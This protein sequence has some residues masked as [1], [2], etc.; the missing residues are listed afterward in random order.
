MDNIKSLSWLILQQIPQLTPKLTQALLQCFSHP[1]ELIYSADLAS[2]PEPIRDTIRALQQQGEA[3]AFY[4][5]AFKTLEIADQQNVQVI[6][7]DSEQYPKL[8]KEISC[9]PPVLYCKGNLDLLDSLQLAV[10]GSRKATPLAKQ[11]CFQWSKSLAE[12]GIT[13]TS[14][15]ALGI[16][17]CAHQG[18]LTGNGKTIAV[19]AHGLDCLYPPQ[20]KKLADDITE[21]GLLISE[22]T[23]GKKPIREFFPQRNRLISG[24]S[25]GVL[26]VE[27][28]L[29]SGSLITARFAMEQNR[30]VF[31]VPS[32][33]NNIMAKGCHHLIKQGALLTE[34]CDDILQALALPIAFN[35]PSTTNDISNNDEHTPAAQQIL[36]N[37]AAIPMH[38]NELQQQTGLSITELS[39]E[40][41]MLEL[42]GKI[43]NH[44]GYYQK[45]V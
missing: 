30:E 14:G 40:L 37:M 44:G 4:Q 2:L 25:L 29:N 31:A 32:S 45:L 28:A 23:F 39:R 10:V 17:S 6:G 43:A 27:A 34:S 7:L 22:F 3:H 18:A 13:I 8:L 12:A 33:I 42:D 19:L 41:I 20:N 16:D 1:N 9:P 26:I 36:A 35:T 5:N 38:I 15:L 21:R 11:T 24:L